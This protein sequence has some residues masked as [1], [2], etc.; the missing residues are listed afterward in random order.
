MKSHPERQVPVTGRYPRCE[1]S[2]DIV[3]PARSLLDGTTLSLTEIRHLPRAS[4]VN[5]IIVQ[6]HEYVSVS[7]GNGKYRSFVSFHGLEGPMMSFATV[8][9][10]ADLVCFQG[11]KLHVLEG[12]F[13]KQNISTTLENVSK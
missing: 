6:V 11:R 3:R 1:K 8:Y 2:P 10:N 7:V 12:R 9:S 5:G 13:S 4:R